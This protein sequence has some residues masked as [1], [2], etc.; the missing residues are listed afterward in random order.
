MEKVGRP[1][2]RFLSPQTMIRKRPRCSLRK[3]LPLMRSAVPAIPA[4]FY[5]LRSNTLCEICEPPCTLFPRN[6]SYIHGHSCYFSCA[7]FL[8]HI[9]LWSDLSRLD[10]REKRK[11]CRRWGRRIRRGGKRRKRWDYAEPIQWIPHISFS[12]WPASSPAEGR[13]ASPRAHTAL[14]ELQRTEKGWNTGDFSHRCKY[15]PTHSG[16]QILE[17]TL[18]STDSA[19]PAVVAR[20]D[21]SRNIFGHLAKYRSTHNQGRL[22]RASNLVP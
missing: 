11:G 5:P 17:H 14:T 4:D 22:N 1:K 21:M 20:A 15:Q 19:L 2:G 6:S 9:R 3:G 12:Q 8:W 7:R 18:C 10:K 13:T 16:G